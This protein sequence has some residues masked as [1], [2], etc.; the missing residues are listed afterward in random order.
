[1][2]KSKAVA[3]MNGRL[4]AE[5]QGHVGASEARD[6]VALVGAI[7]AAKSHA[8]GLE[9]LSKKAIKRSLAAENR[10]QRT[11]CDSAHLNPF[12]PPRKVR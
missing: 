9:G 8:W 4:S 6:V 11:K 5:W 10:E 12:S 3:H 2:C 7:R 1:M